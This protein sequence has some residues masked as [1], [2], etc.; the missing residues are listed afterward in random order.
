MSQSIAQQKSQSHSKRINRTAKVKYVKYDTAPKPKVVTTRSSYIFYC[1]RLLKNYSE[2]VLHSLLND[3][4]CHNRHR[5]MVH[6]I[7]PTHTKRSSCRPEAV[8]YMAALKPEVVCISSTTTSTTFSVLLHMFY[9]HII[10]FILPIIAKK[11]S[12]FSTNISL[13]LANDAR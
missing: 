4:V 9:N 2:Q 12:R 10:Y 7:T 5:H 11:K 1:R 13:Y 3:F 6:F 8:K